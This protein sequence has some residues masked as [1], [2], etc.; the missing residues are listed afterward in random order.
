[1]KMKNDEFFRVE[2]YFAYRH[3]RQCLKAEV[4]KGTRPFS[5]FRTFHRAIKCPERRF[6]F[7]FRL[8]SYFV[9]SNKF[10]LRNYAKKKVHYL[11]QKYTTDINPAAKIGPGLRLAHIRAIVVREGAVIGSNV[12]LCQG[13]TIG[14]KNN[15]D[16]GVIRIGD[17]VMVGANSCLIGNLQIGNNVTIGAMSLINKDIPDNAVVYSSNEIIV[18]TH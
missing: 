13:V 18:R 7:W 4:Q 1:M 10:H 9:Q 12:T 5:W 6:Y 8:W 2:S 11:N 14:I 17:N 16:P 3:L 15:F